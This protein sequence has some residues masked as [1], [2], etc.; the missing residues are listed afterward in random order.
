MK[1]FY[2]KENN[3]QFKTNII[4]KMKTSILPLTEVFFI[5]LFSCSLFSCERTTATLINEKE[6]IKVIKKSYNPEKRKYWVVTE[7][8]NFYTNTRYGVGDTLSIK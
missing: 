2:N 4:M 6:V 8:Y 7:N 5:L 1:S 3:Y